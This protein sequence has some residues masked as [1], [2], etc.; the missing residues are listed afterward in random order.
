MPH[1][2]VIVSGFLA[3]QLDT[4]LAAGNWKRTAEFKQGETVS[5]LMTR[6]ALVEPR[7]S[8]VISDGQH[9]PPRILLLYNDRVRDWTSA[10]QLELGD[11]DSIVFYP[12][13]SGGGQKLWV[14]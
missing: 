7:F 9:L 1:V 2:Q 8:E 10:A 12:I 14:A 4:P 3:R 11:G 5:Q 6:I 13:I